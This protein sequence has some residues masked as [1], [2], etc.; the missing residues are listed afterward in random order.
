MGE[1]Y[2]SPERAF[3]ESGHAVGVAVE[4]TEDDTHS[5]VFF[6]D[7]DDEP[8]ALHLEFH[9]RL[10]VNGMSRWEACVWS[11]PA[12]PPERADA[13]AALCD[14]IAR[15]HGPAGLD[16][17]LRYNEGRFDLGTGE[18]ILGPGCC[19]LTCSTFVLAVFRSGGFEL[20][21]QREWKERPGDRARQ[22]SLV[23]MLLKHQDWLGIPQEHIERVRGEIGCVRFSPADVVSASSAE[24]PAGFEEVIEINKGLMTM[25]PPAA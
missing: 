14:L 23:A 24:I 2:A 25:L 16:Y 22:E 6:L 3:A 9:A 11:S 4:R 8:K 12:I 10:K 5:A 7:E 19:G 1:L 18:L 17:A 15:R 20:L 21:R 13:L